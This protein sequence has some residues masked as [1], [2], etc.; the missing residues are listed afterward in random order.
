MGNEG[1]E[2]RVLMVTL[3]LQGH[4]NPT[5]RFAKR[6]VSKGVHVTLATTE[7]SLQSKSPLGCT[8][9]AAHDH[10][11]QSPRVHFEFFSDGL[12]DVDADRRNDSEFYFESLKTKG[13]INLSNLIT[14]LTNGDKNKK[15][16]CIIINPFTPWAADIALQHEIPCAVLWIQACTVFS[17]YYHYFKHQHLF[18]HTLENPNDVVSLPA[19]PVLQVKELPSFI[20][21]DSPLMK[22][23][24]SD[25]F[26]RLDNI[27][28]VLGNSFDALE[29][30]VVA[31]MASIDAPIIPIGPLV[32]P[33]MF[34]KEETVAGNVDIWRVEDSCI[35][36]LDKKPISSV[37]Y[38][39]FGSI[40][41]L[42][43]DQMDSVATALKNSNRPFLWV[44]KPLEKNFGMKS[45]ELPTE[46]LE[47]TKDRGLVVKWCPQER[48]LMHR[49]IACFVTHCGW[50][51][52][53]ET[54]VAGVPVVAYPKWSDQ[55]TDAKLLVDVLKMG[56]KM[57]IYGDDDGVF[58]D[59][60]VERCIA[61][62]TDVGLKLKATEM[63]KR[64]VALKEAAKKA[65][66][67]GGSSDMNMD[68]F[69]SEIKGVSC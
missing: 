26:Q 53:L 44:I 28:W 55:P 33:F 41:V 16:S 62:V 48:V 8:T 13:S 67:D 29:I 32:S 11:D 2:V 65:V 22:K 5:L 10:D 17:I 7:V 6:L 58:S 25:L 24:L 63:K 9:I 36:F 60:V 54:V 50:N 4:L 69:I 3:A 14:K 1:K 38:I 19:I 61:E 18:P 64:A 51:S 35:E 57:R 23:L 40:N 30:D 20:L 46:F 31:S 37:V 43:Q 45:G 68:R 49:S 47:E 27:K 56:V 42:T 59:G 12:D 15:F 66:D 52:T 34:G 21:P 39:S